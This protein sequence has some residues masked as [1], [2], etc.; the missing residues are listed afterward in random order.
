MPTFVNLSVSSA[1]QD[2]I[3]VSAYGPGYAYTVATSGFAGPHNSTPYVP[4][5]LVSFEAPGGISYLTLTSFFNFRVG[6]IADN[7][8]FGPVPAVPEPSSWA[9]AGIGL[10]LL[11]AGR[12]YFPWR[13]G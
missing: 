8:Y 4:N 9:F 7:L 10:L 6:P 5:E 3:Y 2:R 11:A 1:L 12:R 13:Q